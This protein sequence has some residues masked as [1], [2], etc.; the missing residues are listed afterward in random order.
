MSTGVFLDVFQLQ[1]DSMA[2]MD[3]ENLPATFHFKATL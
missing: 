3:K 2:L 1:T